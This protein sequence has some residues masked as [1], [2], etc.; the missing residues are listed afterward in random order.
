M[1][2]AGPVGPPGP[3]GED[4]RDADLASI[5]KYIDEELDKR[6]ASLPALNVEIYD[7]DG[8]KIDEEAVKLGGTLRLQ[9]RRK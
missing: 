2:P 8:K 9:Y 5:Q 7:E 1:G 4:G 3:R 6:L